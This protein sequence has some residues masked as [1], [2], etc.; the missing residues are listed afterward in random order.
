[1]SGWVRWLIVAVCVV[2]VVLLIA[3]ARGERQRGETEAGH[4]CV[5]CLERPGRGGVI[6]E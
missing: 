3:Y 1:M 4:G 5:D 6:D 2:L